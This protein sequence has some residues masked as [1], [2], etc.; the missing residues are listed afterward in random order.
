[1]F[2]TVL[3][4]GSYVVGIGAILGAIASVILLKQWSKMIVE[5]IKDGN[6][7]NLKCFHKVLQTKFET[8]RTE[9]SPNR[10][11]YRIPIRERQFYYHLAGE[12]V[13]DKELK[14][15]D[16]IRVSIPLE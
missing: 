4:V 6:E 9:D 3:D 15:K 13:E 7:E 12:I 5:P 10:Y 8:K 14:L 1:M 11:T 16:K 2:D